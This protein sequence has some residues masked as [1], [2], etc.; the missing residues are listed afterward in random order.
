MRLVLTGF[1]ISFICGCHTGPVQVD[2]KKPDFTPEAKNVGFLRFKSNEK[3]LGQ[4]YIPLYAA[5]KRWIK[6]NGYKYSSRK[7]AD[8]LIQFVV[9]E[10]PNPETRTNEVTNSVYMA[11]RLNLPPT[12]SELLWDGRYSGDVRAPA[13]TFYSPEN[14]DTIAE[15]LL[16]RSILKKTEKPR[17]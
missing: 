4:Y 6:K 14:I 9:L 15:T 7:Q 12:K 2:Y 16:D 5:A 8:Y 3:G 10:N 13:Q 1:L 17:Q 11:V